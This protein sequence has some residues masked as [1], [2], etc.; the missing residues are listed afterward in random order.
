MSRPAA[1]SSGPWRTRS[2]FQAKVRLRLVTHGLH[3][4]DTVSCARC[5]RV[6][7][8]GLFTPPRWAVRGVTATL[9]S[10]AVNVCCSTC[11]ST[12]E[13]PAAQASECSCHASPQGVQEGSD[14][15]PGDS[16]D[17]RAVTAPLVTCWCPRL[18]PRWA[19]QVRARRRWS[20]VLHAGPERLPPVVP[21][22]V[23][24]TL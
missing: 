9:D 10:N 6:T 11:H 3:C 24:H 1:L 14:F 22:G 17:R 23:S 20:W 18:Q 16:E 5:L 2:G 8:P 7:P 12:Q 13:I 4:T 15:R 21:G 19:W